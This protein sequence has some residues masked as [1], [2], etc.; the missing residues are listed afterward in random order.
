[1]SL[2]TRLMLLLAVSLLPLLA[3]L[4]Y[5][6]VAQQRER[7][8]EIRRDATRQALQLSAELTRL[9]EGVQQTLRAVAAS[10]LVRQ[11]AA[12]TCDDYLHS[13]ELPAHGSAAIGVSDATGRVHCLSRRVSAQQ[14]DVRDRYY[15]TEAM[16]TNE[17]VTGVYAVG[18]AAGAKAVHFGFPLQDGSGRP[19]GVA[20]A[21][22]N[23]HW[24][25]EQL[26]ARALAPGS[27]V[28]ITD[29]HG[30]VL[31]RLPEMR[32][33]GEPL[34]AAWRPLL[35]AAA[36]GSVEL[37]GP[38]GDDR[39]V[40]GYV[41]LGHGP[42]GMF[43]AVGLSSRE[44]MAPLQHAATRALALAFGGIALALLL[45]RVLS[46]RFVMRP[47]QRLGD[48]AAA[49]QAGRLDTRL[50][51][52]D[53]EFGR[54]AR[55][56]NALAHTLQSKERQRDEAERQLREA[57]EQAEASTRSM[58]QLLT[59]ASHDLRQ[60]I[61]SMTLSAALLSQRLRGQPEEPIAQRLK[62]SSSHLVELLN[63]LLNVSQLDAGTVA[64]RFAPVSVGE[65]LHSVA[66]EFQAQAG[67]AGVALQCAPSTAWVRSDAALLRRILV[68]YVSNALKY[69]PRGGE[70]RLDAV[71]HPEDDTVELRV[72]D[73]GIGIAPAQHDAVWQ[74]FRQLANPERDLG[75]GLGLGLAI[76]RRIGAL[77]GHPLAMSS[78]PQLGS[79]FTVTAPAVSPAGSDGLDER[80]ARLRGRVLLVDDDAGVAEST[81]D[82]LRDA[83]LEVTACGSAEA[84]MDLLSRPGPPFDAVLADYRLPAQSGLEVIRAARA[85]W[86]GVLAMMM[87]GGLPAAR[88]REC[89]DEHVHLLLKPVSPQALFDALDALHDDLR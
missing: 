17:M 39:Q 38:A 12:A 36:A 87:S 63:G 75:K 42:S 40:V 30:T 3:A 19:V 31:V 47:L 23:L 9:V 55:A 85:R 77:L 68:N 20:F 37:D 65:L 5:S 54:V 28:T 59:V 4:L 41:P 22:L 7:Q 26:S 35:S 45:A 88:V 49:L 79:C 2:R 50:A 62:R 6:E 56:F 25:A 46:E 15:F 86:P 81:A 70:V 43:V 67:E 51:E 57:R 48:G 14:L 24:L 84:A 34:E 76:V 80:Q 32:R 52:S 89:E 11:S 10:P 83:G 69:T 61:H 16:R 72:S 8:E 82:L 66:E 33:A 44:V 58:S 1:M 29:R 13:L 73:T 21:P 18:R 27:T 78:Q 53:A 71:A 64:P 74:E 60:P